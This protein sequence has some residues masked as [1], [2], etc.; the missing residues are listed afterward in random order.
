MW[1]ATPGR[2]REATE[3]WETQRRP[4][5]S[6]GPAWLCRW[7]DGG[8]L[9]SLLHFAS[10]S[11]LLRHVGRSRSSPRSCAGM[12]PG[13]VGEGLAWTSSLSH[14]S[15]L[16][17]QCVVVLLVVL[18]S[19]CKPQELILGAVTHGFQPGRISS[20]VSCEQPLPGAPCSCSQLWAGQA[21]CPSSSATHWAAWSHHILNCGLRPR[22]PPHRVMAV[23]SSEKGWPGLQNSRASSC[24][25]LSS[26]GV[27]I[28]WLGRESLA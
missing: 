5:R 4:T 25:I 10:L 1:A 11:F 9:G 23:K 8:I 27:K 6:Q 12:K 2:V 20:T 24:A 14:C 15:E 21:G 22:H 16:R 13:E 28:C 19:L 3:A 26:L 7:W 17:Q 18:A